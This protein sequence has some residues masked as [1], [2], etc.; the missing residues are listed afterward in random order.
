MPVSSA[1]KPEKLQ[2][3]E[4]QFV[5]RLDTTLLVITGGRLSKKSSSVEHLTGKEGEN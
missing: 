5:G 2:D 1:D 3:P 4:I